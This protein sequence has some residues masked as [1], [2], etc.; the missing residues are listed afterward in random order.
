MSATDDLRAKT[1]DQTAHA[2]THAEDP[3]PA[4][5]DPESARGILRGNTMLVLVVGLVILLG[6]F[7]LLIAV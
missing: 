7:A 1:L 5:E 4:G 3:S 6:V 2:D